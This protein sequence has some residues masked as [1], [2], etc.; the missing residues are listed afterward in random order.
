LNPCN[1]YFCIEPEKGL[2]M[3]AIVGVLSLL[4]VLAIVGVLINKNLS[5]TNQIK[6]PTVAGVTMLLNSQVD[7]NASAQQQAQQIQQQFKAATEAAMQ[8][9]RAMPDDK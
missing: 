2:T 9:P 8:Q 1:E 3:R 7:I 6:V 4:I 5:S